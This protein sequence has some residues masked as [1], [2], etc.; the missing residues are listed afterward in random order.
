MFSLRMRKGQNIL[1]VKIYYFFFRLFIYYLKVF[2]AS[3]CLFLPLFN[4]LKRDIL[5]RI[6]IKR[7]FKNF[8]VYNFMFFEFKLLLNEIAC[9]CTHG[10]LFLLLRGYSILHDAFIRKI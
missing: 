3:I 5:N 1:K 2:E 7:S 8:S 9:I 10:M 4:L 6:N